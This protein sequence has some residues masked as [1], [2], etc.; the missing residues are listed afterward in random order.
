MQSLKK[1]LLKL[2]LFSTKV[3]FRLNKKKKYQTYCGTCVS[4]VLYLMMVSAVTILLTEHYTYS[5]PMVQMNENQISNQNLD[6]FPL[7][8][9]MMGFGVYDNV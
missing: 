3:E 9:F 4:L 7:R 6:L 1:R 5:N 2:D 8:D